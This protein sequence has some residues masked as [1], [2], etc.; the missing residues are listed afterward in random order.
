M[1]V[2]IVNRYLGL[3]GGAET[4]V[5]ELAVN[6]KKLGVE[7]LV[8]TLNIS[9][10]VREKCGSVAILTPE[11]KFAY[12]FRS[13]GLVSSLGIVREMVVLR[14][15]VKRY[16]SGFDLINVHNFPANWVVA[17]LKKPIVWMCNEIP[18]F[19]NN[20]KPSLALRFL[21]SIGIAAD[22]FMVTRSI[23]T[24]CV[25]DEFNAQKVL[26]RYALPARIVNY[27]IEYD[28][29]SQAVE[30]DQILK[31]F[32]L[33]GNFFL[34]QAGMLSPE[35]DQLKSAMTLEALRDEI[36]KLKLVL[37][38]RPQQ[39]YEGIVRDYLAKKGLE[40]R[41]I[42]TGHIQKDDL[43]CLYQA[44]GIAL[45]PVKTQGGWLSPFEALS[46]GKP[47]IVSSTMGAASII[48]REGIGEVSDDLVS[49]VRKVY[50]NYTFY[51]TIAEK[52]RQW[53]RDNLTWEIFSG[54]ML[55]VFQELLSER[56]G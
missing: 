10:E 35:K 50:N 49:S 18:D 39:P 54:K 19:Y 36:P 37:A 53:V 2:L 24:V 12:K 34:L 11:E 42:F 9:D 41:V 47:V 16:A 1:K 38:G 56:R 45:F 8:I 30:D 4:V 55:K 13:T 26:Q 52:G 44:C 5:R 21:R 28:F 29:F 33:E 25:A 51:Q 15:M 14:R 7:C 6:L 48:K 22:R 27:G 40:K 43:R 17:G 3:Y 31:K 20:P 23:D 46:C 32:G